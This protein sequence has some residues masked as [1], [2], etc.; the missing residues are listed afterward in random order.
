MDGVN[1]RTPRSKI[2]SST[3]NWDSQRLLVLGLKNP[4]DLL[5]AVRSNGG[6]RKPLAN[7][8]ARMKAKLRAELPD[9]FRSRYSR[10]MTTTM[11]ASIRW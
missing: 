2:S 6:I 7:V 5:S 4:A 10:W 3:G 8:S 1:E 11:L 9:W